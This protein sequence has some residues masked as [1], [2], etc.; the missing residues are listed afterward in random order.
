MS[1]KSVSSN[2]SL[3]EIKMKR[4]YSDNSPIVSKAKK[5][6]KK[7][8]Q[9]TCKSKSINRS[10]PKVT[11]TSFMD[12]RF[13]RTV[14]TKYKKKRKPKKPSITKKSNSSPRAGKNIKNT[15]KGGRKR[16]R[17]RRKKKRTRRRSRRRR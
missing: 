8:E 11:R 3:V 13:N 2:K 16:T 9:K 15:K 4:A 14:S 10:L 7:I 12:S 6:M 1:Q 5:Q 17:R